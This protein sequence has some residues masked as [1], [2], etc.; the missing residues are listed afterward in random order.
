MPF[1]ENKL[2]EDF[3]NAL[4]LPVPEGE[5]A[6]LETVAEISAAMA[7]AVGENP[8]AAVLVN[9]ENIQTLTDDLAALQEKVGQLEEF[10][11]TVD[12]RVVENEQ[13]IDK[14][15]PAKVF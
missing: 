13:T 9:E 14:L 4:G 8:A 6:A 10:L 7:K 11:N 12:Q 3:K 15:D 5:D 2:S 1:D